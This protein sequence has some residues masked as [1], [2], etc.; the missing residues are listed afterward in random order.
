MVNTGQYIRPWQEEDMRS[1]GVEERGRK[2]IMT[3]RGGR[4]GMVKERYR[5]QR[6]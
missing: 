2:G 3:G 1:E 6:N 5:L 4:G